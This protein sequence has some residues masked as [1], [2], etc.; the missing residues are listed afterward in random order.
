MELVH[1][2]WKRHL[3][4]WANTKSVLPDRKP[5]ACFFVIISRTKG[6]CALTIKLKNNPYT[7]SSLLTAGDILDNFIY[8]KSPARR[9]KHKPG[10]QRPLL[11]LVMT[12]ALSECSGSRQAGASDQVIPKETYTGTT[13]V[14]AAEMM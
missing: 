12:L 8:K 6:L 13:A 1:P 2:V 11:L 10:K 3:F 14:E 5:T 7:K 9:Q 4:R